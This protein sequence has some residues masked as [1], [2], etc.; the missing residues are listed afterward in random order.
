MKHFIAI[1][2]RYSVAMVMNFVGLVLALT[3]FLVLM[4]QVGYQ[5]NFDKNHPTSGRIYRVDKVGAADDDIFKNI[6]RLTCKVPC[7]SYPKIL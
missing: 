4:L 2:R 1:L 6:I 3:A 7:L 5:M